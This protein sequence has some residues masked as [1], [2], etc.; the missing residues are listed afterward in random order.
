[1]TIISF[2]DH[3]PSNSASQPSVCPGVNQLLYV[4]VWSAN[5]YQSQHVDVHGSLKSFYLT[6]KYISISNKWLEIELLSFLFNWKWHSKVL[7]QI[8][9]C[10]ACITVQLGVMQIWFNLYV[11]AVHAGFL[12]PQCSLAPPPQRGRSGESCSCF[13][14]MCPLHQRRLSTGNTASSLSR[15]QHTKPPL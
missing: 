1:M 4:K 12:K 14:G 2:S 6:K 8:R 10:P 15:R 13:S 3:R 5:V 9:G 7:N 11:F